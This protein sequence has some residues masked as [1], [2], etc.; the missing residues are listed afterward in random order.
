MPRS[1][2][3]APKSSGGP[4]GPVPRWILVQKISAAT[5]LA[6]VIHLPHVPLFASDD[7]RGKIPAGRMCSE[8][9]ATI[10]VLPTLAGL[11]GAK[12]PEGRKIDGKDIWP[13]MSGQPGA[14][15]PHGAYFFRGDAV[16]EGKWKLH[17][18]ARST[19]KDQ[20]AGPCPQLY[21]LSAD[22][23]ETTNL[24][25]KHPEI[26]ERLTKLIEEHRQ[27]IAENK[28]PVGRVE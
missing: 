11:A 3:I 15:S 10:D 13:L 9:A 19:V 8:V 27:E 23:G 5:I 21:D 22:I 28:R 4:S 26:V 17:V 25:E 7:F 1:L 2:S 20:P 16:R 18:R 12:L 24:A 14:K 6:A